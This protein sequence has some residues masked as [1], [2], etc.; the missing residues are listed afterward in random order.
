MSGDR[1]QIGA[2]IGRAT[3][4]VDIGELQVQVFDTRGTAEGARDAARKAASFG[5][6]MIIGPASADEAR[7]VETSVPVM[8][9]SNDEMLEVSGFYV[10]GVTAAQSTGVV[11]AYARAAGVRTVAVIGPATDWRN[12]CEAAALAQAASGLQVVAAMDVPQGSVVEALRG[13]TGGELP[14]AVLM[15]EGGAGLARVARELAASSVQML[16][17][18]Q[19]SAADIA[20]PAALG[21]W[22]AAPDPRASARFVETYTQAHGAAPGIIGGLA[23]DA[24]FAATTLARA[25]RLTRAGLLQADGFSGVTGPFRFVAGQKVERKLSILVV[26]PDGARPVYQETVRWT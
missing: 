5:A 17:T 14:N 21:A 16:G 11:L 6:D 12:R 18:S 7:A 1:E 23:Y 26:S 13:A 10:L 24:V 2:A 25:G 22:I 15:P 4:L 3:A 20:T 8:T 9:F 19:W